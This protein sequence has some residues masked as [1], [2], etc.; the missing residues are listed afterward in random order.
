MAKLWAAL[1]EEVMGTVDDFRQKGALGTLRDAALD[2]RDMAT[3]AGAAIIDGVQGIVGNDGT[4][5]ETQ[6]AAVRSE[7]V[8][9]RGATVPL[10]FADGRVMQAVVVD[11][12]GVSEPPR[13]RVTVEGIA[14]PLLVPILAPGAPL[15]NQQDG[16]EGRSSLLDMLKS[17]CQA[18]VQE[19]R[20]KGAV[21]A[22]K[23]ATLDA[24]DM[25][26]STAKMAASTAQSATS[27]VVQEFR[28]K[29][30]VGALKDAT[31]DA[32][33]M[34]GSAASGA[35]NLVAPSS[36][37]PN[38]E[39]DRDVSAAAAE[40]GTNQPADGRRTSLL[41]GLK[42]EW[43][44]TVKDFR[45]KGAVG[46]IKDATLDAVDIVGSTAKSAA[47]GAMS[48]ASP[49]IDL[50][51]PAEGSAD[52]NAAAGGGIL[53][54]LKQELQATVQDFREKGAIGAMKDATLD[55]AGMVGSAA[56]VV[57]GKAQ[58]IAAPVM[59]KAHEIAFG[60]EDFK[61]QVAAETA[62]EPAAASAATSS[63]SSAAEARAAM[64]APTTTSTASSSS[65]TTGVPRSF[66]PPSRV[67]A[68][69][70]KSEEAAKPA[71]AAAAAAAAPPATS[72]SPKA[73]LPSTPKAPVSPKT[74]TPPN[75]EA[76][77][78]SMPAGKPG[79]K[80]LV[81]MR[82]NMFEKPK[83]APKKDDEELID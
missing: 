83:E 19:F 59:G 20:E 24:V 30:A 79:R 4:D 62:G 68:S 26:G 36:E 25:V 55:A 70:E 8:P 38:T 43:E 21:G 47:S 35:V 15:A 29:G 56:T 3:G 39:I 74:A 64:L 82:R 49:L 71:A 27:D 78:S 7:A 75:G 40:Q 10:E 12:D 13:A 50:D 69:K 58:E 67:E 44:A 73:E 63:T 33:D 53:D 32:V 6:R 54:G 45:E 2:A 42:D 77:A 1:R 14:E 61:A 48:L 18:T 80:S 41:D 66:A 9:V 65:A 37:T 23:D 31:M 52:G 17:E 60:S 81:E 51:T 57:A 16:D 22:L 72:E 34:V 28:E 11:I 46:A 76:P 5:R